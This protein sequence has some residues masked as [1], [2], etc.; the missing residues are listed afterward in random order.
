MT[1][2]NSTITAAGIGALQLPKLKKFSLDGTKT[3]TDG[4]LGNFQGMP[5]L[6]TLMLGGNSVSGVDLTPLANLPNVKEVLL[7]GNQFKGNDETLKALKALLPH[8]EVNIM[9]G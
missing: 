4:A 8:C 3:A 1:L 5:N 6:E 2:S 9:R 7:M